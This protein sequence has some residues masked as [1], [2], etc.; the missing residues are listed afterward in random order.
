MIVFLQQLHLLKGIEV[1][2]RIICAAKKSVLSKDGLA[3]INAYADT[4]PVVAS[5]P[6]GPLSRPA[7]QSC[8]DYPSECIQ[9][10][11]VLLLLRY[12]ICDVPAILFCR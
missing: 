2:R 7:V 12:S 8:F 10:S 5:L 9:R 11:A 1:D 6:Y 4:S 3:R